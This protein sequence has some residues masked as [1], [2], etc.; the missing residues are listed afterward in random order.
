MNA[1][2]IANLDANSI[3]PPSAL[4]VLF[5]FAV[6]YL[7]GYCLHVAAI[8]NRSSL[9]QCCGIVWFNNNTENDCEVLINQKVLYHLQPDEYCYSHANNIRYFSALLNP[10]NIL[11]EWLSKPSSRCVAS[12]IIIN[13]TNDN[14]E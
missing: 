4:H 1:I 5:S 2:N 8:A 10:I 7:V 3:V 13:D 11:S 9:I 12:G 6:N 14:H